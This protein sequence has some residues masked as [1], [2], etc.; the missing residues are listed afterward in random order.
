MKP[1]VAFLLALF[2]LPLHANDPGGGSPGAGADVT[3]T[4]HGS[5]VTLSNGVVSATIT[6]SNAKFTAFTYRG[7]PLTT[8]SRQI[9]YSM[10]GGSNYRQPSGC[11]YTV[12][13]ATPD[14]IDIGMRQTW[15]T[16]AQAVDI[17]IHYVLRR[18][19][20]GIYTYA[21]LDHPENY[22]ATSFG[23]WRMVWKLPDDTFER[24]YVDDLRNRQMPTAADYAA[25]SPTSIAEIVQLNTG[26]LAGQYEG[27]YCYNSNYR[28]NPVWGHA[29]DDED[30]GVWLVL[31][32]H[33]FFNDGPMKQ[34]LAPADR[35]LHIHFGMNHYNGSSTSIAA[36]ESWRKLY[37]P[38]LLY[39]NHDPAGADACW[40]DAKE[41]AAAEQ[42]A[43]PYEWLTGNPDY[44]LAAERA[45]VTGTLDL[46]DPLKPLL[47][48]AGAWV[49]LAAPDPGGN[50]QFESKRYQHWVKAGP[51]GSFSIP[52]VRP[53]T[54]TLYA[55]TNGATGE[56]QHATPVTVTAGQSL[57]LGTLTWTIPRSGGWLAWEIGTADRDSREFHHGDDYFTPHLYQQFS[58]E[59]PNPLEYTVGVSDPATDWN[60][61]HGGY[62]SGGTSSGWR[63][64]IHFDLPAVPASGHAR[65]HLAFAGSHYARMHLYVND[66]T[67]Q[68]GPF[69]YPNHG[70]GNGLLRQTN[71]AKYA[72]HVI[73]IPVSRLRAGSNTITLL[74]GRS[75][76]VSDH[77]MYDYLALEMPILPGGTA[78]DADADG[79]PDAWEILHF[80][81]LLQTASGDPDGDGATNFHEQQA[82][83]DPNAA[84]S[85]PD[86]DGDLLPDAWELTHYPSIHSAGPL[87]D[88]DGDGFDT[89]AEY[90]AGTDPTSNSS[91]PAGATTTV[92]IAPHPAVIPED[93]ASFDGT[94]YEVDGSG[95]YSGNFV[96]NDPNRRNIAR[97]GATRHYL[98]LFKFDLNAL[99]PGPI[100]AATLELSVNGS[101]S[102]VRTRTVAVFNGPPQLIQPSLRYDAANPFIDDDYSPE[103]HT[104]TDFA[105]GALTSLFSFSNQ[106]AEGTRES[107]GAA[108]SSLRNAIAAG[109][110]NDNSITLLL[111]GGDGQYLTYGSEHP[112]PALHPALVITTAGDPAP[113]SDLDGLPD[114]WEAALLGT[115]ASTGSDDSDGDGFD[116]HTEFRLGLDPG[117]PNSRFHA[118]ASPG[119]AIQWP[120]R[121]GLTFRIERS[122]SL[123]AW[124]SLATVPGSDGMNSFTDPDPLPGKVFYRVVLLP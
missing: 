121:A 124:T 34:D 36:G 48:G 49:G 91:F 62:F 110:A 22:P 119:H 92:R 60:Y 15:T 29:T 39:C 55:F 7:V 117:D 8:A 108:S 115:L 6:K 47:D 5:S 35:I 1:F 67:T 9:Y 87:D 97:Q 4:D 83:T 61:A 122:D 38:F 50:W 56:Y 74:Q 42:A 82:G 101:S 114:A 96:I 66:E 18:G 105:P 107:L 19:D 109:R 93:L 104:D 78:A 80:G 37:G 52:H 76:A 118:T 70:N 21:I 90:R 102:G 68:F 86:L 112:D 25:A 103:I 88:T 64:Q 111:Y 43:W 24:L 46:N 41:Q 14:M 98:N 11:T 13:T 69:L 120:G 71:L 123:S 30:L 26:V 75:S 72:S 33:E 10:D 113:D 27:K 12:K 85:W 31:G 20:S 40:A 53:G 73:E 28:T 81:N 44:P 54:Y 45:T 100:T 77:V 57:D 116:N 23:E 106:T 3:L 89:W 59:F 2:A 63:W 51:G 32:G 16:Q 84:D 58:S 17:E 94:L 99:P 79:L 95:S 65:L